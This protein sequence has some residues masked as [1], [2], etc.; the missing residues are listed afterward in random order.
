MSTA[1]HVTELRDPFYTCFSCGHQYAPCL[2][3]FCPKC[4]ASFLSKHYEV[5]VCPPVP[6]DKIQVNI[7]VSRD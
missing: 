6:V 7:V 1:L 4:K 2:S 5:A 3:K